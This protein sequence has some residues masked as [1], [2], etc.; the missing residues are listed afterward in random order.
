MRIPLIA[1]T[2]ALAA[3]TVSAHNDLPREDWCSAGTVVHVA[4]FRL[5]AKQI[6]A[7]CTGHDDPKNPRRG[8]K[9]AGPMPSHCGQFDPPYDNAR[10]VAGTHCAGYGLPSPDIDF[11][12]TAAIV[13]GPDTYLSPAHHEIYRLRDGVWG[14]CAICLERDQ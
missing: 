10:I 6:V 1:A 2:A 14:M 7:G 4:D 5:D 11:G 13:T 12:T 3:G 8:A 9:R